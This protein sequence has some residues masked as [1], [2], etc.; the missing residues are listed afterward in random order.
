MKRPFLLVCGPRGVGKSSVGFQVF[1]HVMQSGVRTAYIDLERVSFCRPAPE[2]DPDNQ[3]IKV[4]NLA[5]LWSV[6]EQAGAQCLVAAGDVD[7][8]DIADAYAAAVPS[9]DMDICQLHANVDTLRQHLLARGRG[10]GP[11]RGDDLEG[12]SVGMLTR[13]AGEAASSANDPERDVVG[14]VH[15]VTDDQTVEEVATA[16][17]AALGGWPKVTDG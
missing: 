15:V 6:Y 14:D 13:L 3:R 8:R 7:R 17:R 16:V 1:Y 11:L 9:L 5:R 12:E 4:K 2:D 10:E